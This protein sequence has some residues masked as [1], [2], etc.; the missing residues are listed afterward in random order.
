MSVCG[1]GIAILLGVSG[2]EE[3]G[4]WPTELQRHPQ[5]AGLLNTYNSYIHTFH[6]YIHTFHTYIDVYMY[7]YLIPQRYRI[8]YLR[9]VPTEP[10]PT[11]P[12]SRQPNPSMYVCM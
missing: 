1:V 2:G 7:G 5:S 9:P 10:M 4:M 6:T 12:C 8:P 3:S 11:N